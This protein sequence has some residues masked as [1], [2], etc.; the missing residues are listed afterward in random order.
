MTMTLWALGAL[1]FVLVLLVSVALHELGHLSVAKAFKLKVPEYFVGFGKTLYSRKINGTEY[2]VKAI[3]LGGYVR[4]QD[5]KSDDPESDESQLL[6]NVAPWKRTLVFLAGPVV[7]IVIG[8]VLFFFLFL[9]TT[10]ALPTNSVDMVTQ[11]SDEVK[12][13]GAF[14]GG[15]RSGD[16]ITEINGVPVDNGGIP[17]GAV[18]DDK[19][20]TVKYER[21]G[22]ERST[23]V[24]PVYDETSGRYLIG[25]Q[26][27]AEEGNLTVAQSV[28]AT[29]NIYVRNFEAITAIPSKVPELIRV[30][31]GGERSEET[32]VSVVGITKISGDVAADQTIQ[33][34]DKWFTLSLI[35]I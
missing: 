25:V 9:S 13:C 30:I 29:K 11:C 5:P 28:E 24:T 34:N 20:I 19:P 16:K 3:P 33:T 8:T 17:V 27:K 23:Q 21:D 22:I 7:N 18:T 4:I 6:S 12:A 10:V 2:G 35:H 15:I 26:M 31:G 1:G 14:D 32:P